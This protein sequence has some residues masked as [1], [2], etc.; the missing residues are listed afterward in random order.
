MPPEWDPR[1]LWPQQPPQ[2]PYGFTQQ[3]Q[4]PTQPSYT[5]WWW[6]GHKWRPPV[7]RMSRGQALAQLPGALLKLIFL[8][9]L[10]GFLGVILWGLLFSH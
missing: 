7:P 1:P 9:I 10:L 4:V 2:Q 5:Q 3:P 8:L 6:D